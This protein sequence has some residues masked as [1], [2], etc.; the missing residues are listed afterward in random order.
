MLRLVVPTHTHLVCWHKPEKKGWSPSVRTQ[1]N[2]D[3]GQRG[4][5][6][7][8]S[9]YSSDQWVQEGALNAVKCWAIL[10][11]RGLN[12]QQHH[13][14]MKTPERSN[15]APEREKN[16]R[17]QQSMVHS[18]ILSR[19]QN[20]FWG[21]LIAVA[22]VKNT[23]E[24]PWLTKSCKVSVG[25]TAPPNTTQ[26]ELPSAEKQG[27]RSHFFWAALEEPRLLSPTKHRLEGYTDRSLLNDKLWVGMM[28]KG[29]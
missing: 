28:T 1:Q 11:S 24:P 9:L 22:Y 23:R 10:L 26:C 27:Q 16:C 8:L 25:F 15:E 3:S 20:W 12:S 29:S 18:F 7:V 21:M 2:Q 5:E 6:Q 19:K 13:V 14:Q 17:K 4:S